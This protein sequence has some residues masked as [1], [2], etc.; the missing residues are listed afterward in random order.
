MLFIFLFFF[1]FNESL[2]RSSVISLYMLSCNILPVVIILVC[3]KEQQMSVKQ[4]WCTVVDLTMNK[5][6]L[7]K[8]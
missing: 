7:K 2:A 5:S 4:R 1:F 8:T 6:L 3:K